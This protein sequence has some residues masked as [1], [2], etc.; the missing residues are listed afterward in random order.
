MTSRTI[1]SQETMRSVL[2]LACRAPSVHNSQPWRWK[3]A[4]YSVR[5][6]LDRSRLLEVIDPTGREMVISCGAV[7]N[8]A[9]IAFA[10]DEPGCTACRTRHNRTT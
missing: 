9:R 10:A 1:P 3:L 5:L 4:E 6:Y 2:A 8:H 7:L